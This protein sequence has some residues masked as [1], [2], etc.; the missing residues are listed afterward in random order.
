[1]IRTIRQIFRKTGSRIGII[2][3]RI[4]H[5]LNRL[6]DKASMISTLSS[7][8]QIPSRVVFTYWGGEAELPA[9][10]HSSL[11]S[12]AAQIG[13]PLVLVRDH[14]LPELTQNDPLPDC[15]Q[16]LCDSHKSDVL[17][18][19]LMRH[20]GGGWSDIKT[21]TGSWE[22]S[23]ELME[24]S[25]LYAVGYPEL[26][27]STIAGYISPNLIKTAWWSYTIRRLDFIS[28]IGMG[29]IICKA[30]TPLINEIYNEQVRRLNGLTSAL[31]RHPASHPKDR[32]G[33]KLPG[34]E[35]SQYPV[36]WT[37]LLGEIV[38]PVLYRFRHRI[39][40]ALPPPD[41]DAKYQDSWW[42][43]ESE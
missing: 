13:V 6:P 29:A 23:F 15:F 12:L 27:P 10:R 36:P 38:H 7:F 30:N 11:R 40:R 31:E 34:K 4:G 37:Y 28:Q 9:T 19:Y 24:R 8:Q 1:M 32:L 43:A 16:Y 35:P 14:D 2:D 33:L 42:L 21:T 22:P 26:G 17:R 39:G 25:G 41:F 20:F 5:V 3:V 18:I